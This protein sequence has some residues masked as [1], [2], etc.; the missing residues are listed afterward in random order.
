MEKFF[1]RSKR[2]PKI[3]Q[4]HRIGNEEE[5]ANKDPQQAGV[6]DE[7]HDKERREGGK[8]EKYWADP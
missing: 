2:E 1:K 7:V 6:D 8:N 3:V 4:L 5:V